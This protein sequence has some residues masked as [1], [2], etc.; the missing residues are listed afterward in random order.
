[1]DSILNSVKKLLGIAPDYTQFDADIIMH[2]NAVFLTLYELG[3]GPSEAFFITD[4]IAVWD[5]YISDD[6]LL[7]NAVR[8]YIS[9][10]VR[11]VFDPPTNSALIEAL[12]S[13]IEE[14]EWR[15]NAMVDPRD[16]FEE[17]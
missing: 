7:L 11:L 16:T 15:M 4:D 10:K 8:I 14:F 5:D 2:I 1:M 9:Q 3:V 6:Y 13:S 17:A 12:K